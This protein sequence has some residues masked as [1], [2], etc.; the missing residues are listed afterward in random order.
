MAA[1]DF[2]C[3]MWAFC[4]AVSRGFSSLWCTGFLIMVAFFCCC[5]AWILDI[6]SSVV[7][8]PGLSSPG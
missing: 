1:L 5:G 6:R 4:V 8:V 3:C 7:A 2:C